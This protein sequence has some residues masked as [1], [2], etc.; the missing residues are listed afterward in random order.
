V[1]RPGASLALPA[2]VAV[3]AVVVWY[4]W[5]NQGKAHTLTL[6]NLAAG[7]SWDPYAWWA[8]HREEAWTKNYPQTVGPNC[9]PAPLANQDGAL[10]TSPRNNEESPYG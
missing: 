3:A 10:S 2:A 8:H 7:Q 5:T 4:V 9:L 6:E 1:A